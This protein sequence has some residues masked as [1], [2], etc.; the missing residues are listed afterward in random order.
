MKKEKLR[1]I[2]YNLF[3]VTFIISI[4]YILLH[5][6]ISYKESK[7]M[8]EL[9]DIMEK[10]IGKIVTD[11]IDNNSIDNLDNETINKNIENF[12]KVQKINSDII[13]WIEIQNTNINYPILQGKDNEYYLKRNYKKEYS[14][15][16]SI[17]L[18][19]RYDFSIQNLNFLVYGHNNNDG[20]MFNEL[21][22]YE[23]ESFYKEHPTINIITENSEENYN[24]IAVFKSKVY[25]TEDI[26]A[27]KYYNCIE[28]TNEND[29]YMY[30]SN[31][32]N[33]SLY[34]IDLDTTYGDKVLTLSTCEYSQKNG[35]FV[36]VAINKK[37]S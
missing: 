9:Q 36:V 23:Q 29:F 33:K 17:F 4:I 15:N 21:L 5:Y 28:L 35:R 22:N 16:G 30:I 12:K 6:F 11:E 7:D 31:C 8:Q 19:S 20:K 34:D 26:N 37:N 24:I 2:L 25:N 18:D 14:K 32:Q 13:A 3:V 1:K 27:F 10:D